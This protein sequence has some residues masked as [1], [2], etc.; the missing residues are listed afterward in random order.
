MQIDFK[1]PKK[2]YANQELHH[3]LSGQVRCQCLVSG[4]FRCQP[5]RVNDLDVF[6]D[7]FKVVWSGWT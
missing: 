4:R 2:I 6:S 5:S 7:F 3:R 1:K